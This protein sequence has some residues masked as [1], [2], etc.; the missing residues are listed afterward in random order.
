LGWLLLAGSTAGLALVGSST[1]G[2][3][4]LVLLG[5]ADMAAAS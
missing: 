4:G 5:A 2:L 3:S 1:S